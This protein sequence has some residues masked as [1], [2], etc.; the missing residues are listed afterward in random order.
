M[1]ISRL[2]PAAKVPEVDGSPAVYIASMGQ[3]AAVKA[4]GLVSKL[5]DKGVYAECDLVGRSLKAQMKYADKIGARYTLILGDNELAAGE[6]QLKN[7]ET[8]EQTTVSIDTFTI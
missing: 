1:G 2:L 3:A 5:R 4:S 6:A 8:G 7:M